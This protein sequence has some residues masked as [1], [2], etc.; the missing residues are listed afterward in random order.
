MQLPELLHL[1]NA[2]A[3][4]QLPNLLTLAD[5]PTEMAISLRLRLS[6]ALC[7]SANHTL[8]FCPISRDAIPGA[9]AGLVCDLCDWQEVVYLDV[10]VAARERNGQAGGSSVQP[11]RI[12]APEY[13]AQHAPTAS[14]REVSFLGQ[15]FAEQYRVLRMHPLIHREAR[16]ALFPR[17][18][19]Q[20]CIWDRALL[21]RA[22]FGVN[23]ML[24]ALQILL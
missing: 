21:R 13:L 4:I 18:G 22:L 8:A 16:L 19:T 6:D 11:R 14:P 10:R 17:P 20:T 24:H 3:C 2:L 5:V 23:V 12:A 9:R 1:I 15:A 7:E